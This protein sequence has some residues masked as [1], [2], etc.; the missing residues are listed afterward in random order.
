MGAPRL[1][2]TMSTP[3]TSRLVLRTGPPPMRQ[4][5]SMRRGPREVYLSS[6]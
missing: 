4:L 5:I 2:S 6:T 1:T 3:Q